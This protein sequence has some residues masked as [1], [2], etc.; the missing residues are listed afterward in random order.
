MTL[1]IRDLPEL[2]E[3]LLERLRV[4]F[5][6][7]DDQ[8][9]AGLLPRIPS[10]SGPIRLVATGEYN[11]GKS[12]LLKALTGAEISIHS[13]VTTAEV[14]EY[15]WHH[16]MLV[17]TPGVKAGEPL[18]DQ[19]AEEALRGADL[20]VFVIT[21]DLFDDATAAHLRH[22]AF[23]LGKLEQTI[24]VINKAAT[25]T[26]APGVREAA[27]REVL[28][29]DWS[30]AVVEC[31]ARSSLDA[32]MATDP[33]RATYL[34]DRGNQAG[35]ERAL[36]GLVATQANAGR[37]KGPFEAALAAVGDAQ[38]F[39]APEPAEQAL[40]TLLGRRQQILA[41]SRLRLD[42][43]LDRVLGTT[44]D[45]IIEAGDALVA[46]ASTQS[47]TKD[48]IDDFERQLREH[49][50]GLDGL[51]VR[52]FER[53]L[54]ELTAEE[55]GLL[56]GPEMR[57]LIDAGLAESEFD[58]NVSRPTPSG[59]TDERAVFSPTDPAL[60]N[61][62]DVQSAF[63]RLVRDTVSRR[64]KRWI[65]D[66]MQ[67]GNRPGSPLHSLVYEGGK[68]VGHKFKPWQAVKWAKRLQVALQA[69]A[70]LYEFRSQLNAMQREEAE[71]QS[72]QSD[73]RRNVREAA[74]ALVEAAREE[75]EPLVGQF[76]DEASRP[77]ADL[78]AQLHALVGNRGQLRNELEAIRVDAVG[79]LEQISGTSTP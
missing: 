53:E 32:A 20:V 70:Y 57:T 59:T 7:A 37:L 71:I 39:L 42:N 55:R 67:Q 54:N 65:N 63:Y 18:H 31:D 10:P 2:G 13:D 4:A 51:I 68:K 12:S 11:A 3:S 45:R 47:P 78:E 73:V 72:R 44:R 38:P 27:V 50:E 56:V 1:L 58:L 28:G 49:A 14:H 24:V 61:T 16:V 69:A 33:D 41:E 77:I 74:D 48:D 43:R 8:R 30:G 6:A 22:V 35:L 25:M 66:A 5:R 40:T 9:F 52:E 17:D 21:V 26:G 29:D 23:G 64:G 15:L 75:L 60:S 36:N 79:A 62:A 34:A 46:A 76:F 19:R